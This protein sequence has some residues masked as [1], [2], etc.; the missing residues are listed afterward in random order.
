MDE[1]KTKRAWGIY[2]ETGIFTAV[3]QHGFSLLI[4]DMVQSGKLYVWVILVLSANIHISHRAKYP[5]AVIV[6]LMDVFGDNLGG[7]YDIGCQFKTTL[8][9]SPLGSCTCS[10]HYTSLVG[11]FHGHAHCWLCQ[12][13]HLARYIPGL[14]LEDLETC[15]CTFSKLNSL[16]PTTCYSSVFHRQQ[17]ITSYF[18][19]NNDYEVY[20]NL[21]MF[22]MLTSVSFL[23]S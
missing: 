5:L 21:C 6:K 11:S 16:A 18:E 19:Y 17:A 23:K 14:G 8:D 1:E 10:L 20:A 3:C 13:D 7:G 15:K 2:D 9:N 22:T 4:V 12:L